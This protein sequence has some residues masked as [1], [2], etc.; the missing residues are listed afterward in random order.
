LTA[1]HCLEPLQPETASLSVHFPPMNDDDKIILPAVS[2]KIH[3]EYNQTN[4]QNDLGLV[5]LEGSDIT[6]RTNDNILPAVS[7]DFGEEES[8]VRMVGIGKTSPPSLNNNNQPGRR[9][10]W[11]QYQEVDLPIQATSFCSQ[12]YNSID[13]NDEYQFCAGGNDRTACNGDSGGPALI[14]EDG[15]FR[16]VGIASFGSDSC[17]PGIPIVFTRLGPYLE[18][19]ST[20]IC[21]HYTSKDIQTTT[22][23]AKTEQDD[24][25]KWCKGMVQQQNQQ[26]D[27][28]D[29]VSSLASSQAKRRH[30]YS[31]FG[32][33][34]GGEGAIN[35]NNLIIDGP[36]QRDSSNS[37]INNELA[38]SLQINTAIEEE[39]SNQNYNWYGCFGGST[40]V[41]LQNRN[42]ISMRD[43]KVGDIVHVDGKGKYEPVYSFGH[44]APNASTTTMMIQITTASIEQNKNN[45]LIL[46]PDHML[47]VM[48]DL[49]WSSSSSSPVAAGNLHVGDYLL[50][51]RS[52]TRQQQQETVVLITK[53]ERIQ[54]QEEEGL[55]APFTPS[56]TIVVNPKSSIVASNYIDLW[57]HQK[58]NS[59][60]SIINPHWVTHT[61]MLPH[62]WRCYHYSDCSKE[63]RNVDGISLSLSYAMKFMTFIGLI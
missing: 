32:T 41:Q 28:G 38:S 44:W 1:A 2:W 13:L 9:N 62:R 42:W 18:W 40:R 23:Y 12:R 35:S 59:S 14:E 10:S 21:I 46:T 3:P 25:L 11:E 26:V 31:L 37:R 43:L 19:I 7:G 58:D 29:S 30:Q 57:Y 15:E 50:S 45:S 5:F 55:Y 56:G 61:A 8:V 24:I 16:L 34:G 6:T 51:S 36:P 52:T 22:A 60:R 17:H 49:S 4:F 54:L 47:F 27:E 39:E 63:R 20:S 53:V 33:I 48:D